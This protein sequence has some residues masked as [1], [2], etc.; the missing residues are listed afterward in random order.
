MKIAVFGAGAVGGHL[1]VKLHQAGADVSV[2]A[3]G[4]HLSAIRANGLT[5]RSNGHTAAARLPATDRAEDLG[6]QDYVI[7]TLKANAL[8]AAASE[9][10][11]LIGPQTTLVTSS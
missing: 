5:V 7:V 8:P 4:P 6:V 2:I 10:A 1:A 3:R 11:K 9:I